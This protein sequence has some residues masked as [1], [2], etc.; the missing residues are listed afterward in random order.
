MFIY[1]EFEFLWR[2]LCFWIA[3]DML[4]KK[5]NSIQEKYEALVINI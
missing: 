4:E 3:P 1:I 2:W 5:M